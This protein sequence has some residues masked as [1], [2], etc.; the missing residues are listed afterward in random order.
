MKLE[1]IMEIAELAKKRDSLEREIK[2]IDNLIDEIE[3]RKISFIAINKNSIDYNADLCLDVINEYD[4]N[5]I[6]IDIDKE[7]ML[8]FLNIKR[9]AFENE[10]KTINFNI[11]LLG[12]E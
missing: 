11:H 8:T 7:M 10:V 4:N 1:T 12:G 5:Y 6:G 9:I 3:T 2:S